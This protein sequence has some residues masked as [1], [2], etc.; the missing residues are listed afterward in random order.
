MSVKD[1]EFGVRAREK[2]LNGVNILANAVKITLGPCG[3]NVVIQKSYGQ[4]HITKDGVTVAREVT[5]EDPFENMGAQVVKEVASKTAELA[6]DGTTT[7]PTGSILAYARLVQALDKIA[8]AVNGMDRRLAG[9]VRRIH[10]EQYPALKQAAQA[11]RDQDFV[12]K[13]FMFEHYARELQDLI[14]RG[15]LHKHSSE[16]AKLQ[17]ELHYRRYLMEHHRHDHH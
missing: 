17:K 2:V 9:E 6:G 7:S 15:A 11:S 3:R 8:H 14:D 13:A 12:N 5:L 10:R 1:F 16:R 4:P